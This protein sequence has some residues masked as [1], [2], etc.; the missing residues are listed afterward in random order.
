MGPIQPVP[1]DCPKALR[2]ARRRCFGRLP[3]RHQSMIHSWLGSETLSHAVYGTSWKPANFAGDTMDST[4]FRFFC[5]YFHRTICLHITQSSLLKGQL[6]TRFPPPISP[7]GHR[8]RSVQWRPTAAG[9]LPV[10]SAAQSSS[11]SEIPEMGI[12]TGKI[13]QPLLWDCEIFQPWEKKPRVAGKNSMTSRMAHCFKIAMRNEAARTFFALTTALNRMFHST[14]FLYS[15]T[16][17]TFP[18][19][20]P[21]TKELCHSRSPAGLGFRIVQSL[22]LYD[23][24]PFKTNSA[25][26]MKKHRGNTGSTDTIHKFSQ[27]TIQLNYVVVEKLNS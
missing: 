19:Q 2:N 6:Q 25:S 27:W 7:S 23:Y 12:E 24:F 9:A 5:A 21:Q 4:P 1:W 3:P 16:L 20:H 14:S 22:W 13:T 15:Q 26:A 17:N 11:D 8:T 18:Q 10:A